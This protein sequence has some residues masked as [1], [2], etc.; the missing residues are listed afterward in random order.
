[1][2]LTFLLPKDYG[3]D[4]V[5]GVVSVIIFIFIYVIWGLINEESLVK[6]IEKGQMKQGERGANWQRN[7]KRRHKKREN[8]IAI[9]KTITTPNSDD[10]YIYIMQSMNLYKVGISNNVIYRR[11]QIEKELNG[12]L[13]QVLYVGSVRQGRTIDA[14]QVIHTELKPYNISVQYRNGV[15]SIEW[16]DCS[17]DTIVDKAI[18]Y[19]DLIKV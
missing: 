5:I 19:A 1:M 8:E 15:N 11:E 4:P 3:S 18:K 6:H 12:E 13:V 9:L 10:K 17:I 7:R 14:E 2:Y 16:F